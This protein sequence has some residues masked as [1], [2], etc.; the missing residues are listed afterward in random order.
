MG[1][2]KKLKKE[3]ID[4]KDKSDLGGMVVIMIIFGFIY[5]IIDWLIRLIRGKGNRLDKAVF[6]W[7]LGCILS[8]VVYS[9]FDFD[10]IVYVSN[11]ESTPIQIITSIALLLPGMIPMAV[12]IDEIENKI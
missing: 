12:I 4:E 11:L 10:P 8:F 6:F 1:V 2:F 5:M 9:I 7:F 3:N